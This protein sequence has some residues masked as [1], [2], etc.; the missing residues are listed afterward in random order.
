M[1]LAFSLEGLSQKYL[2]D[3]DVNKDTILPEV[4]YKRKFDI[5]N[6]LGYGFVA[7]PY[8]NTPPSKIQSFD[9]WQFREGFWLRMK[10]NKWYALGTYLEYARDAYRLKTP[11]ITDSVNNSKTVWTKQVNNNVVFGLFNR[12]NFSHDKFFMD[13]GAYYAYDILPRVITKI[14]PA[15]KAFQAKKTTYN[16]PYFMNRSNYG[17]DA[18]LTYGSISLYGKYR[19]TGL[20][21]NEDYDLPKLMIGI[22][23]DY[24]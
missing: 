8:T 14:E 20:Y 15:N 24:N 5:T 13:L 6:Y 10:L 12:I 16:R 19:I 7:G 23:V 21:K 11:I 22:L 18:R 2:L 17:I 9:S 4:G 3:E 1:L